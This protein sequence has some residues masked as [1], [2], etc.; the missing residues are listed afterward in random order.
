MRLHNW[1]GGATHGADSAAT[2]V[3]RRCNPWC[4]H[5]NEHYKLV[6]QCLLA[7]GHGLVDHECSSWSN[8]RASNGLRPTRGHNYPS[9]LACLPLACT[10]LSACVHQPDEGPLDA[11]SSH[12]Q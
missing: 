10:T 9:S 12:Q 8:D 3:G 1:E 2:Q 5:T 7:P 4:S 6:R 11:S